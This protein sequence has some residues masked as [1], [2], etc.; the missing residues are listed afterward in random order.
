MSKFKTFA[1]A[2]LIPVILGSIVGL[3]ISGS[4]D[5]NSLKQ[6]FFA[7]PSW[8]FPIVWSILYIL[9]GVSYGI[10]DINSLVD[11]KVNLIYYLQLFVNLLWPIIFFILKWRFFAFLWIIFL[12]I[13]IIIMIVR[14][15]NKDKTAALLQIPYLLWTIFA[16]FLNLSIYLLNR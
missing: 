3:L 9:M 10:L 13:L 7:P 15:Y 5:Y 6:P 16:T 11:A 2:I 14:F 4:M 8:L 1:K 12:L